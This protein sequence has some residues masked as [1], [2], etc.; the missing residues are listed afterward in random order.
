MG[1]DSKKFLRPTSFGKQPKRLLSPKAHFR[2]PKNRTISLKRKNLFEACRFEIEI[3]FEKEKLSEKALTDQ[4]EAGFCKSAITV[5]SWK[6]SLR[7]H[8]SRSRR[9]PEK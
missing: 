8:I 4:G 2:F 1:S 6:P 5:V 9:P 7:P 3:F